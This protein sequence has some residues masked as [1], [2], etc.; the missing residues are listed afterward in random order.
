MRKTTKKTSASTVAPVIDP[1]VRAIQ[2]FTSRINF[3]GWN[4]SGTSDKIWGYF[5]VRNSRGVITF[6]GKRN[7]PWT[8]K[9]ADTY[10][11]GKSI[12]DLQFEK[13]RGGYDETT[14]QS[15]GIAGALWDCLARTTLI[16]LFHGD[17]PAE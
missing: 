9:H 3:V 8:F 14:V 6:W 10:S 1:R 2:D 16:G 5:H 15:L 13:R 12:Y 4:S 17:R 7:G 11:G